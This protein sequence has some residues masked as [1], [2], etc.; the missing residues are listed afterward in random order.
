MSTS[1]CDGWGT[2]T[3]WGFSP[4]I[5]FQD[6]VI[7]HHSKDVSEEEEDLEVIN[8]LMIGAG[9]CRHILKTM[10]QR[11]RHK[12]RKIHIYIVENNFE[13]I[14]R[15]LLL[16]TLALEPLKKIGLQEKVDLFMELYGN[17][18]IRNTTMN[19]LEEKSN[20]FI[21]MITDLD[22]ADERMPTINLSQLKFKERDSLENLFKFWRTRT[23]ENFNI[24]NLWDNRLRKYL[25]RRYDCRNGSFDWDLMMKLHE[26]GA[27]MI[28]KTEYLRWREKGIAFETRE[29]IY[30]QINKSLATEVTMISHNS[31]RVSY[32]GYY[33]DMVT[34][35]Y[36]AFGVDSADE[37]VLKTAN[38][39]PIHSATSIT[40]HNLLSLFYELATQEAY[41][42]SSEVAEDIKKMEVDDKDDDEEFVKKAGSREFYAPIP[43][44]EVCVHFLPG[45]SFGQLHERRKFKS[46]FNHVF[47]SASM[48]VAL[49]PNLKEIIS[50][51]A[52][53]TVELVKYILDLSKDKVK[54]FEE[55]IT[56]M[57]A[58]V[59]FE[60]LQ[61]TETTQQPSTTGCYAKFI[62]L[63]GNKKP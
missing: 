33:G 25:S 6:D 1:N 42:G 40:S 4:A 56:E 30:N 19:Y 10:A 17:T 51:K 18:L 39:K 59:G 13:L 16:L 52:T 28:N 20:L 29:G 47:V 35:P 21:E 34:G 58:Q 9:D 46:F 15:H 2:A 36:I 45:S 62:S 12:K 48:A 41:K 53:L 54:N 8:I 60:P 49:Q 32:R 43:C 11:G 7:S 22:Y 50:P 26:Y 14:G 31:E 23:S 38:G 55:R 27:N 3:L 44:E 57:A 24:I 37:E 63:D 5:D 61:Q